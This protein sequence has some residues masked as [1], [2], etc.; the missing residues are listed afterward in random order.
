MNRTDPFLFCTERR[1]VQLT[2]LKAR[3]LPELVSRL[4]EVPGASVFYHTHH[5]FLSHHFEKPVMH[6]DFAIWV[7]EAL[8]EEA[9]GEK[10]AAIDLLEFTSIRQLRD[11]LAAAA[12]AGL[13]SPAFRLR[14]CPP[15]DEF[16]FCR[17]VSFVMP[18]G[19]VASSVA[20]LF[21]KVAG[22]TNVSL[23]F[24]FLEAR[25]RLERRT[26]DFSHWLRRQGEN[27]LADAIDRLDPYLVTL[28]ELRDQIVALGKNNGIH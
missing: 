10:L 20:E 12:G 4:R 14:E 19:A 6:N 21:Q 13:E 1:L 5:S 9:L 2:G 22:I 26:N 28:D 8:Q 17:S 3:T 16:H 11:A 23:Y 18:T 25:L 27:A 15:G 7:S 24:H